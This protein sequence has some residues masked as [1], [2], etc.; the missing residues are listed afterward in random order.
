[1][2]LIKSARIYS[3]ELPAWQ[4]LKPLLEAHA[5]RDLEPYEGVYRGFVPVF[6]DTFVQPFEGGYAFKVKMGEKILPN[7]VVAAE[8]NKRDSSAKGKEKS[9]LKEEVINDLIRVAFTKEQTVL[10][11]YFAKSNT[12]FVASTNKKLSE[13]AT[14]CLVRAMGSVKAT[15]VYCDGIKQSL[16]AKIKDW[17]NSGRFPYFNVE[18]QIKDWLNSGRF[19][20]F[21]V[22]GQIK[23][24]AEGSKAVSIKCEDLSDSDAA[25]TETL[26]QNS[27]VI[28]LA[29]SNDSVFFRIDKDFLLKGISFLET[30][31]DEPEFEDEI[32]AFNHYAAM[33]TLL[34]NDVTENLK[35]MFEYKADESVGDLL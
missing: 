30:G 35:S 10:C 31:E 27:E 8:M 25:I 14:G 11:F 16:T 21:N 17:L 29:L 28:E 13:A 2:K 3:V 15:T 1:M 34:L 22:E 7:S 23:L 26:G 5:Y 6:N 4:Q 18:G 24:K 19:P 32:E 33:Q 9:L 12:L 20:Y